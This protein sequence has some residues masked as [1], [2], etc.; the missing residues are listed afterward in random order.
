MSHSKIRFVTLIG[1]ICITSIITLQ[2]FWFIKAYKSRA[3]QLELQISLALKETADKI[4]EYNNLTSPN[5][6]I[7]NQVTNNYYVVMTN[8]TIEPMLL[9]LW[10]LS[11]FNAKE[12]NFDFEYGIY[13]CTSEKLV[14][15]NRVENLKSE[16]PFEKN[17][18]NL[19][20]WA[21]DSHYFA[22]HFP[23]KNT[24]ILFDMGFWLAS[25]FLLIIIVS[26]FSYL[27][28]MVFRQKKLSEIHRNFVNNMTHEFN[29]PLTTIDTALQLIQN[30]QVKPDKYLKIIKAESDKLKNQI[31]RTL[32]ISQMESGENGP[33]FT[34]VHFCEFLEELTTR[35]KDR[36]PS[37]EITLLLGTACKNDLV[38]IDEFHLENVMI[39]L[40][41][42]ALKYNKSEKKKIEIRLT[43]S[44]KNISVFIQDNG[45]GIAEEELK[46]I[47]KKFYRVNTGDIHDQKGFGLGLFYVAEVLKAIQGT[48]SVESKSGIG[49]TFCI[50]LPKSP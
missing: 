40:F 5:N 41:D 14:F 25:S 16:K 46:H 24:E 6:H 17:N 44:K 32:Q 26:Y 27:I 45:I 11:A 21:K 12:L 10:L 29:T 47:F 42:N 2:T 7:I 43:C 22:V 36:N 1:V 8:S 9:E 48:I 3:L 38:N 4:Y 28:W 34:K 13:D 30:S 31:A 20:D 50:T 35:Y 37:A 23:K 49:S 18:L 15:S 33:D 39:N 19:P